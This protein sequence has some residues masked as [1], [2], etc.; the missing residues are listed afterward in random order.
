M[1]ILQINNFHRLHGGADRVYLET[2]SMLE[3]RGHEVQ[4][5]STH[6]ADNQPTSYEKYFVDDIDYY[7][8]TP[9]RKLKA[10]L[11]FIYNRAAAVQ[12]DRLLQEHKPDLAHI[13]IYQGRLSYSI[14][15]VLRRHRVPM[16]FTLHEYK[17]LCPVYTLLNTKNEICEACAGQ[18]FYHCVLNKCNHDNLVFSLL[19]TAEAYL[20]NTFHSIE[21]Y[22]DHVIMVSDFVHRKH[23][24][25]R[26]A[27]ARR[28]SRLYN[29]VRRNDSVTKSGERGTYF[30]YFGRLVREKGIMTLLR[31]FA[32]KKHL[33]LVIAGTG[34]LQPEMENF[35]CD[36]SLTNV[37]LAGYQ[38][39]SV[40]E[41]IIRQASFTIV[42]S[43]WYETF[44][45]IVLESMMQGTPVIAADIG[46]LPELVRPGENGFLFPSKDHEAL[47]ATL[48]QVAGMTD[49]AYQV[50]AANGQDFVAR[51]FNEDTHYEKLISIYKNTLQH[52]I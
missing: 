6:H 43:E 17:V 24:H 18:R 5:F 34:P 14:L 30:L 16:I 48:E 20:R 2:A 36:H 47:A 39:G 40:L 28:S 12:L 15:P 22:G 51:H 7:Y 21:R 23:V 52:R 45:L 8:L 25:H 38:K 19:S 27:L 26:P 35:I 37:T 29:F 10:S 42:P 50:M 9:A 31:S 4:F 3:A 13:H 46:A 41:N 33:N 11:R 1:K 44:G 49:E 32:S